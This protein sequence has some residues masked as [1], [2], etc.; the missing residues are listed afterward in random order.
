MKSSKKRSIGQLT[1]RSLG[2]GLLM[3][4]LG[5]GAFFWVDA[6]PERDGIAWPLRSVLE[7]NGRL[8]SRLYNPNRVQ[9]AKPTL[10]KRARV[11]GD[12]G[13]GEPIDVRRW[14]L[15][16]YVEGKKVRELTLADLALLPRTST[17]T[18]FR[19]IEG[20]SQEISYSGIQFGDFLKAQGLSP[21]MRYVGLETP[22]GGY[23]VSVDM[24][25]MLHVQTLLADRMNDLPLTSEQG[26]PLRL[27]IPIK[28]GIKSLKRIGSIYL[29]DSRPRD[30]WA[31]QGYDWYAGL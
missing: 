6:Q 4:A 2:F 22:D 19:C 10:G 14:R 15:K 27:L 26:A 1:R 8:W 5:A 17:T 29:S 30:Y 21:A 12:E 24:E 13:L 16:I 31:E 25:S 18:E 23:Y 28:Y 3:G 20:W 7:F 9:N 11:N